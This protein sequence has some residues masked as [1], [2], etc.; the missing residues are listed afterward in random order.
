MTLA[1]LL[2]FPQEHRRKLTYWSDVATAIAGPGQII[3]T[4]EERV[5]IL[6]EFFTTLM[7]L[8]DTR[9]HDDPAPDFASL[10]AHSPHARE[11]TRAQLFGDL[12]VLLVG[13]NDTTRN[14]IT[15]SL[16]ALNRWPEEFAKLR[17][18]DAKVASMVSETIR[19]Q[20]PLTHM[21]RVATKDTELGL[22][23]IHI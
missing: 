8:V 14:T 12:V 6:G 11:F 7:E 23:L 10:L 16:Y 1:T 3:E 15:G 4:P 2:N 22:S 21:M 18:G 17:R 9:Q 5:A 20:T 13:G 19:W